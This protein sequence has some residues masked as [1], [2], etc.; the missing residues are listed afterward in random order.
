MDKEVSKGLFEVENPVYESYDDIFKKYLGNVVVVTNM[1][2]GKYRKKLGAIVRYYTKTSK[3]GYL[4]KWG[5]CLSV[6]EYGK[7]MFWNLIPNHGSLGGLYWEASGH[8]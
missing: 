7:V 5:E 8:D 4:D 6:P 3:N 1:K 2:S